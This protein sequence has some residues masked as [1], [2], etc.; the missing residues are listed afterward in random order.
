M[1]T[2]TV[3]PAVKAR[4]SSTPSVAVLSVLV[5]CGFAFAPFC[6]QMGKALWMRPEHQYYPF[7]ILAV[8]YFLWERLRSQPLA[9]ICGGALQSPYV[10]VIFASLV[11]LACASLISSPWLGTAASFVF[12]AAFIWRLNPN[13]ER[14]LWSVWFLC[15][16]CLPLPLRL[17]EVAVG[18]LQR[19]SSRLS[20]HVLDLIGVDHLLEGNVVTLASRKLFVDE[21]C[22]GIVSLL[23]VVSSAAIYAVWRRYSPYRIAALIV[24]GVIWAFMLNTVRIL[25]IAIAEDWYGI[26]LARG[27]Q[28]DVLGL[29]LFSVT[30]LALVS[31]DKLLS[32][33]FEPI[34]LDGSQ[35]TNRAVTLWNWLV[36]SNHRSQDPQDSGPGED[37]RAP[38]FAW[39][40]TIVAGFACVG[41]WNLYNLLAIQQSGGTAVTLAAKCDAK[42]LDSLAE[43]SIEQFEQVERDVDNPFGAFSRVYTCKSADDAAP[44]TF[45]ID[46]PF[47]GEWHELTGCYVSS[48]WRTVDRKTV[49]EGNWPCVAAVM[50]NDERQFGLLIFA[51]CDVNGK[52]SD[53]PGFASLLDRFKV[54]LK[55]MGRSSFTDEVLQFQLWKVSDERPSHDQIEQA[56]AQ[57]QKL[58]ETTSN[59][60]FGT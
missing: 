41:T 38:K 27:T 34:P 35:M 37:Y 4:A 3:E 43:I 15:W 19:L 25:T 60:I 11:L 32:F 24:A 17:N 51:I 57:F 13:S 44:F 12:L 16:L 6:L 29:V 54:R 2:T 18:Q 59:A 36:I 31:T 7:V 45:A 53:V 30:F 1:T 10:F 23:S 33:V 49:T 9:G 42:T 56:I 50:E 52:P 8:G 22:S 47:Y 21:A 26:D 46:Y 40:A 48:G 55:A 5:V 39:V 20:S 58:R 14:S 28:H